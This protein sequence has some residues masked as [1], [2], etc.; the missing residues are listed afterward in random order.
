MASL[1]LAFLLLL[2]HL[3]M[4]L[5]Q[6]GS[7][8][9][10]VPTSSR[11]YGPDGP[12]QAVSVQLGEPAQDLDLYPGGIFQSQILTNQLC[13]NNRSSPCGSGGLFDTESSSTFDDRSVLWGS[14]GSGF[15]SLWTKGATMFSFQDSTSILEQ[16]R[17]PM[18]TALVTVANFSAI[19]FPHITMVYPDG[20]YPLQV[21]Q[22]ALGP[23]LNQTFTREGLPSINASLIPGNLAVQ[24]VIPSN[25]F[26]LHIG[27]GAEALKLSLSLWL[28]G[29]D[30]SRIVGPVSN[31]STGNQQLMIDLLDI[32]IGVNAGASPFSFSSQQG[33]L[34]YG[35][36]SITSAGTSV[37]MNPGAPYLYLPKS[38]CAAIAQHLPV[39][40]NSDKALY[41]WKVSDPHYAKI[42]TSPT[43]LSFVFR[44]S[45]GNLTINVPFQLLNLT[46]EG[47]LVTTS[48]P[49]FPCQPP[50]GPA[51]DNNGGYSLGRAFLQAAFIGVN[52]A[53]SEESEWFL[54]QAP[55]PNTDPNPQSA[56][57]TG[58]LP[59]GLGKEWAD[60]WSGFWTSL[61]T[62]R[63]S[64]IASKTAPAT[65]VGSRLPS[66]PASVPSIRSSN[67]LSGGAIVGIAIG[68]ACAAFF[69]AAIGIWFF[70]RSKDSNSKATRPSPVDKLNTQVSS[71]PS[72]PRYS[73]T[74]NQTTDSPSTG[75]TI[76]ELPTLLRYSDTGNQTIYSPSTVGH[77]SELPT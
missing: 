45:R 17:I 10:Q 40:Y 25:S 28:G 30:A 22:L 48:T 21:G 26:G 15:G 2:N 57:Y 41:F 71:Y 67:P 75:C 50:Q 51:V 4:T 32:T 12:W 77:I 34:S 46:L 27:I 64:T 18:K 16:L 37:L 49:Y 13:L 3:L 24:K 52:W 7:G 66:S 62:P 9:I 6:G 58:P 60:T 65:P 59:I 20:S 63:T 54:A 42:V 8:P 39:T 19:V 29:Y 69:A 33:L 23:L 47:P 38:T 68:G 73:N 61:P 44:G 14:G 55:G 36:S 56:T 76:S 35:N 74:G 70:R 72:F 43:Y 31:Q 1:F 53:T 5:A 11:V